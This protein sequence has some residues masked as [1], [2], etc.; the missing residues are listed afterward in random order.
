MPS[1]Q[2]SIRVANDSLMFSAAHF[3][4]FDKGDCEPLHGHDYHVVA[5]LAGPLGEKSYV[6]DFLAVQAA[7]REILSTLDHRVLLPSQHPLIDVTS[8]SQEITV[9][10]Q[11]LRWIFPL[12]NCQVLDIP[13]TTSEMLARWIG[14]QLLDKLRDC[15]KTPLQAVSIEL[16]DGC[17]Q[18]A[19]WQ[20]SE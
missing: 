14:Q 12:S 3:I 18:S 7:L 9:R 10:F 19:V 20:W 4:T 1:E 15:P 16:R 13:N 11:E 5:E 6:I 17:G 8:D 2:Y